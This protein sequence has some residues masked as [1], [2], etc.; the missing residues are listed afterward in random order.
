VEDFS[1]VPAGLSKQPLA[2]SLGNE[3]DVVFAVP[4]GM[5]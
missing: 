4:S 2:P 5:G 1:Q 3:H